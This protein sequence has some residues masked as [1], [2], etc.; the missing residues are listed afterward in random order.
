MTVKQILNLLRRRGTYQEVLSSDKDGNVK[1][2]FLQYNELRHKF[3]TQD[4][5]GSVHRRTIGRREA[6]I[7][8]SKTLNLLLKTSRVK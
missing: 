7:L 3:Y 4:E 5:L 1:Y 6:E 2:I 8:L